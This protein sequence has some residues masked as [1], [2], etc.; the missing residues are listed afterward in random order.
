MAKN[1]MYNPPLLN[2]ATTIAN[3]TVA[4]L[5]TIIK[6]QCGYDKGF[7]SVNNPY[8][9]NDSNINEIE[10]STEDIVQGCYKNV[11]VTVS[12]VKSLENWISN[13]RSTYLS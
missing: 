10:R 1:Y 6:V 13:L 8:W 11:R 2:G 7:L 3:V 9:M 5:K 4:R 12:Q